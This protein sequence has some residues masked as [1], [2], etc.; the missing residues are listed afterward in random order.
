MKSIVLL[1]GGLDS[2]VNLKIASARGETV[3]ALTFDYGQQAFANEAKAAAMCAGFLGV[4][5]RIVELGWYKQLLPG[6]MAGMEAVKRWRAKDE[7]DPQVALDEAWIPN[8]NGVFVNIAAAFAEF[9]GAES[10]VMGLNREEAAVFPD[11][12]S[13]FIHACNDSLSLSTLRKVK[14]ISYTVDFGKQEIVKLGLEMAAPLDMIYSCYLGSR[15]Q[16]M[17]GSCQSCI[18]LKASLK[19]NGIY[20]KFKGRFRE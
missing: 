18:R 11:N 3:L 1:S 19:A 12:S 16:R 15:D 10:I 4:P 20:E 9:L 5:H 7:I 17:C 14:V 8:R 2:V 6:A 13:Q